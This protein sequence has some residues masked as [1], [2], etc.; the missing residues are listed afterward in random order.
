MTI[1]EQIITMVQ[2]TNPYRTPNN[3]SRRLIKVLEELGEAAEAYLGAT[4]S[5]NYKD[6][7]W[8]DLRE[9]AVDSLIVLVDVALTDTKFPNPSYLIAP[10]I[11]TASQNKNAV[12]VTK[13]LYRIAGSVSSTAMHLSE[14]DDIGAMGALIKGIE[15]AS[16][17]AFMNTGPDVVL[18]LVEQKLNKWKANMAKQKQLEEQRK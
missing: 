7:S 16:R 18:E 3:L 4:S 6:K 11:T 5:H 1:G 9:E 17:I 14:E 15:S 13:M 2:D 8:D 10:A 12:D